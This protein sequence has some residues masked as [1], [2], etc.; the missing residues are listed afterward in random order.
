MK[1]TTLQ[2]LAEIVESSP[3][4]AMRSKTSRRKL[5]QRIAH[6]LNMWEEFALT[7]VEEME[8]LSFRQA[9]D[10]KLFLQFAET[11]F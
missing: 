7:F 8:G 5:A 2:K 10:R 3:R 6:E 1:P 9:D 11:A 4:N